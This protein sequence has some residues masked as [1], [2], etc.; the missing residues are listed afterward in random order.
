MNKRLW[1]ALALAATPALLPAQDITIRLRDG[2]RPALAIPNF[3]GDAAAQPVMRAFNDTLWSDL[4]GSGWFS[5]V[6]KTM[7][8]KTNPQQPGDWRQATATQT[9]PQ[10]GGGLWLTDWSGPPVSANYLGFGYAAA[11]N[12]LLAL[13]GW[14]WDVG[15]GSQ[16]IAKR[17]AASTVNEAGA[18]KVAHEFAADILAQ[19]GGKPLTGTHIYFVSD[20]TGNKE[21]W[22][23]DADGGNERQITHL[24]S[25]SQYPA[26]SPD[27]SKIVFTGWAPNPRVFIFSVDPAR[28]VRAFSQPE[29]LNGTHG[30]PSFTPDGKQILYSSSAPGLKPTDCCRVFIANLD[31]SGARPIT[32]PGWADMA[33]KA[34]PKTGGEIAFVSGRSGPGQI[35]VTNLDGSDV[36][37]LTTGEGEAGS[38]SWHPNGQMI[39]Y[40]STHGYATGGWNIFTMDVASQ[41]YLQ[42]THGEG[43]NECPSWAPD[44]VHIVFSSN[45]TGSFQIWT[46]LADGTQ[47]RQLT[48]AGNNSNPAWGN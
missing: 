26:V 15:R 2:A 38:P 16:V 25:I 7:Y 42:L 29:Y 10:N 13:Y 34:N 6:P 20:R 19:F 17:Y 43:K 4:E 8:P 45:R 18:R 23:M 22:V 37:R 24:N 40:A 14:L 39:A 48:R 41:K 11:Q 33:P 44:G 5:L 46:M 30:A 32:S 27:G 1:F 36:R 9:A 21:I 31:G 28:D 47:L 12:N 35:Y 3:R